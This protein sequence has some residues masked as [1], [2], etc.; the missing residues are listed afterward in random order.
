MST[1]TNRV[2]APLP[3]SYY[4]GT[5]QSD[6]QRFIKKPQNPTPTRLIIIKGGWVIPIFD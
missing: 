2:T 1:N 3:A 5:G 6:Y 4:T